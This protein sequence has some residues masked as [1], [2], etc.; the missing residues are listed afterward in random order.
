MGA[1]NLRIIYKHIIPN[2][3]STIITLM[4]FSVAGGITALTA[5]DFLSFGLPDPSPN[6][7]E[8][9]KQ[10]GD[11]L[12]HPRIISSIVISLSVV[13][14]M[15]TFIGEAIREVFDPKHKIYYE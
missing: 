9:L 2:T 13:L 7:G 8:L 1:S 11:N 15:V 3:V 10:G 14:M 6:W 4:P 5:L 12:D